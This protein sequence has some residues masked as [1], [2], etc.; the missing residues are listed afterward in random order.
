[1]HDIYMIMF[2][3]MT[4]NLALTLEKFVRLVL[5]LVMIYFYMFVLEK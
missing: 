2:V 1:M 4:L 3:L 5:L